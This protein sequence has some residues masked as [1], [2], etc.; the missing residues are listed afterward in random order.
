MQ[1]REGK[2]YFSRFEEK[3]DTVKKIGLLLSL[4][5]LKAR[6]GAFREG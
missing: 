6:P 3:G 5:L 2:N 1:K 4:L